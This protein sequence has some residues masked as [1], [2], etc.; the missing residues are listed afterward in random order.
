MG[1]QQSVSACRAL[2]ESNVEPSGQPHA[3]IQRASLSAAA[4][5]DAALGWKAAAAHLAVRKVLG[6]VA[7]K[8]VLLNSS[9]TADASVVVLE[10]FTA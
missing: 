4:A 6:A 2:F 8:V 1:R 5:G 7:A 3:A 10:L 9:L